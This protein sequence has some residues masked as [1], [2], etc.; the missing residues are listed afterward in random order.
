[1]E[2][3]FLRKAA[4]PNKIRKFSEIFLNTLIISIIKILHRPKVFQNKNFPHPLRFS[5][6]NFVLTEISLPPSRFAP[7]PRFSSA[8]FWPF[9]SPVAACS[10]LRTF[11]TLPPALPGI[12]RAF[13][14]YLSSRQAR[15][16]LHK[17]PANAPQKR[18]IPGLSPSR[19]RCVPA[20]PPSPSRQSCKISI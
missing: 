1:M 15:Q 7:F 17:Y 11:A 3:I 9:S 2:K 8:C 12:Y 20:A 10:L 4:R 19:L 6:A 16:M 13:A 5:R 14:G 18:R